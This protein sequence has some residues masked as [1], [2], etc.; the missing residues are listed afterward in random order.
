MAC[1][2]TMLAE[3]DRDGS[4]PKQTRA[5]KPIK[6]AAN[7]RSLRHHLGSAKNHLLAQN[8]VTASNSVDPVVVATPVALG[9]SMRRS[10]M[11]FV[12]FKQT[13]VVALGQGVTSKD[14]VVPS[15]LTQLTNLYNT[16]TV[17]LVNTFQLIGYPTH[18][19]VLN[20]VADVVLCVDIYL[21]FHLSHVVEA[22]EIVDTVQC[23][24]RYLRSTF[25][26]DVLCA[27][28]F[29]V[30]SPSHHALFRFCRLLRCVY[31]QANLTEVE[32]FVPI[33]S[34]KRI[35]L[36][37]IG[38]FVCYHFAGCMVHSLTFAMGF[39]SN[40]HGWLPPKSLQLDNVFSETTGAL[41]GY[42]YMDGSVFVPVDDA[43][44]TK[45]L[46][47][48]YVR[49][50]HN[51][52]VCLTSLS[53]TLEPDVLP[54]YVLAVVLMLSGMLVISLVIDE[55]QKRVTASDM[56]Q[57]EFLSLRS[58]VMHFLHIQKAP[59]EIHRRVSSSM[60]F[61][62]SIHRGANINEMLREVPNSIRRDIYS[63]I[64]APVL[65]LMEQMDGIKPHLEQLT[66]LFL[67]NVVIHLYGQGEI[68]YRRGDYADALYVL[69]VGDIVLVAN[70]RSSKAMP[71]R[72][73]KP[74][75]AVLTSQKNNGMIDPDSNVSVAWETIL[76][77]GAVF[78]LIRVPY[79][80][81]FG[82][83]PTINGRDMVAIVVEVLFAV[84]IVL[85]T[86]TGYYSFGNKVTDKV[87]IRQRY[88]LSMTFV[89]DVVAVLPVDLVNVV[90][91][92]R[93]E[94]LNA[95][96]LVR[97][98]KLSSRIENLERHYYNVSIPI[99]VFKL[100]FYTFLLAHF[101]G[102]TW[103][104]FASDA[105]DVMDYNG[106]NQFGRYPWLP[107]KNMDVA[108]ANTSEMHKYLRVL[109]W[110]LG[111]SLGFYKGEH[112]E[113]IPEYIFTC[114]VQI[115]V[116]TVGVFL[117][118]YLIGNL[119]D[120]VG[121]T[122][123]NNRV[124]YSNLNFV[125]KLTEYFEFSDDVKAKIQHYYFYRLFHTIH[126]EHVLTQCLPQSLVADIR[127]FLLTPM[128]K[129]VPFFQ[130]ET[131]TS[132]ITRSL[133]RQLTQ[134]LVT[135]HEIVCR[136][137]E[138]GVDMYFVFT[139]CLEVYVASSQV[140]GNHGIEFV[141][142]RGTKVN[143]IVAG[144]FF[145]EKSLFSDQPRN[146]SI[147]AKTFCTLY[148]LSRNH[149]ESVFAQ[150]PEWKVKVMQIVTKIYEVQAK[151][152]RE[153]LASEAVGHKTEGIRQNGS[154]KGPVESA[155]SIHNLSSGFEDN[156]VVVTAPWRHTW[157]R[158]L[159]SI[160]IQSRWYRVFLV[161]LCAALLYIAL[162]VPYFVTFGQSADTSSISIAIVVICGVV[163]NFFRSLHTFLT[164]R[165]TSCRT[166]CL[167]F[168]EHSYHYEGTSI[169]LDILAIVPIDYAVSPVAGNAYIWR[170]NR[171]M[172]LRQLAHV[173][174]ELQRFSM[175][176][177][178]HRLQTMA[179]YYS[180]LCYWTACAFFGLT[181][182]VGFST[183]WNS[184]LPH[185]YFQSS[186]NRSD[187]LF[188]LHQFA[189]CCY[190][191][192]NFFTGSG[193]VYEPTV[194][195][196]FVFHC[197][198]A[199]FGVF[200][201]GYIIGEGST[202]CIYLIQ[203]EVDY[204]INQMNVMDFLTR[205]RVDVHLHSRIQKFMTFWWAF[206]NGVPYQM[207]LEQLPS[208]IRAQANIDVA[209][210]SLSRF[211]VR[212]IRPLVHHTPMGIDPVIHS[213]A[214][215][216]VYE[217]YPTGESVIVQGN[218]GHTM[219]FVSTGALVS[220]STSHNFVSVRYDE[221]Q[222]FG[223]DGLFDH[224]ARHYSVVTLRAC[225]LL[226]LTA[227]ALMAALHEHP[228]LSE[229]CKVA[230]DIAA[231][232]SKDL[233]GRQVGAMNIGRMVCDELVRNI[234][235][236]KYL[237][238]MDFEPANVMFG[239]FIHLFVLS[240]PVGVVDADNTTIDVCQHC[241]DRSADQYCK[242]CHQV[243][244]PQ[245]ACDIHD[246]SYFAFHTKTMTKLDKPMSRPLLSLT[247]G[248]AA[249]HQVLTQVRAGPH[250]P[251]ASLYDRM[252]GIVQQIHL[253]YMSFK[254]VSSTTIKGSGRSSG[255]VAPTMLGDTNSMNSISN[256]R[257]TDLTWEIAYK[258]TRT[259]D[260][261]STK[262]Q[263]W[264]TF[265]LV[266][267]LYDAW[268]V[269][270]LTCF[271]QLNPAICHASWLQVGVTAGEFFFLLD[272]YVQMHSRVYLFG[273][274]IRDIKVIRRLYVASWGFPLD[275]VA[276][277]PLAAFLPAS[278]DLCGLD[279][280]NKLLRL[281]KVHAYTLKVD[282]VFARY[283]K[284]C[285]VV[286]AVVVVYFSCHVMAC[287]YASFGKKGDPSTVDDAWKLYDSS[288][289]AHHRR[290]LT[291]SIQ[292]GET[293]QLLTEY[294]ASLFCTL[295]MISKCDANSTEVFDA[296][297]NQLKYIMSFHQVP[298]D[299]QDRAIEYLKDIK[300]ATLQ[301]MVTSVPFFKYCRATFVRALIDLMETQSVP[302]NYILCR[303]GE[304][305]QDMYFV[306]SGVMVVIV[307]NVKV[308]E[309][310]SGHYF[311]EQAIF[312]NQIRSATVVASTFCMLQKLS[313]AH[314][315][316]V[317]QGYPE[318]EGQI[319]ACVST[320]AEEQ[321]KVSMLIQQRSLSKSIGV[322]AVRADDSSASKVPTTKQDVV[323]RRMSKRFVGPI[324]D[325][326][327]FQ[328]D[329]LSTRTHSGLYRL[330]LK[331]PIPRKS[332]VRLVWL[333]TTV[334]NIVV[335]PFIN[336]FDLVGYPVS[337]FILNTLTDVVLW[338]DI[339]G[340]FNLTFVHEAEHVADTIKCANHYYES[341]FVVDLVS[342]FP[343]W[344]VC[345][346]LHIPLRG[347]LHLHAELEEMGL[348]VRIDSRKRIVLLGLGLVLC[349]HIAGCMAHSLTF[350]L[351]Y[352]DSNDGW[353]PPKTIRL[354]KIVDN[355]TGN[356]VG[357]DY[358]DGARFVSLSDP[359]V[360]ECIL[361]QYTRA[362]QYG[363]VCLT[364]LGH[365]LEPEALEEFVLAL[366]LMLSGMLLISML[367]DDVQ[368]CVTASAVEQLQ[369][370]TLRSR[371]MQFFNKEKIPHKIRRRVSEYMD[372]RWSAHR[373]ANMNTLLGELPT[374]IR[375]DI[376]GLICAP[377]L[378]V[379]ELFDNIAPHFDRICE[380]I[381]DNLAVN[382]Y[383]QGELVYNKGEYADALYV[384]VAGDVMVVSNTAAQT[385]LPLRYVKIAACVVAL[386]SRDTLKAAAAEYSNFCQGLLKREQ[387]LLAEHRAMTRLLDQA[388]LA[389]MSQRKPRGILD[390]DSLF[391]IAWDTLLFFVL[392]TQ[393]VAIPFF[394]AF[395]YATVGATS[396][397]MYSVIVE[398][399]FALDMVLKTRTGYYSFGNKVS[400]A[401]KIRYNYFHSAEF[402]WNVVAILPVD[403]VAPGFETHHSEVWRLHKLVRLFTLPGQIEK[404][405]HYFFTHSI[406]IRVLKVV[407]FV[408]LLAHYVGCAWYG[409]ASFG[410]TIWGDDDCPFGKD[411]WLPSQDIALNHPGV[412]TTV[413][414]TRAF[415]WGLGL[416]LGFNK[417]DVPATPWEAV[418]TIVV[419]TV[420]VFLLAYVV[421]N[422]LDVAQIM[423]GNNQ[424]FYSNLTYV[425]KL[426]RYF[427]FT[428]DVR[429]KIQ[430]FYFYRLAHNIHEEHVLTS[431]LPPNLVGDIRLFLLTPMLRK[432]PFFHDEIDSD[433]HVARLLVRH[434]AQ[435]LV[436]R[437]E[438]VCRQH[439]VG[440][441]MYFVF[442]G[443]L[444]VLV[445]Q[446]DKDMSAVR[447]S[448]I[449][450]ETSQFGT[451]V[452][453]LH[454]GSFFGERALFSDQPRTATIQAKTFCTLYKLSRTHLESVFV[455]YPAW[456]AKVIQVVQEYYRIRQI[457][458]ESVEPKSPSAQP[459][460]DVD[461][462]LYRPIPVE[463]TCLRH[464]TQ[465][466]ASSWTCRFVS[467]NQVLEKVVKAVTQIEVQS[468][469]YRGFLNLVRCTLLYVAVREPYMVAF[470]A[471]ITPTVATAA[472]SVRPVLLAQNTSEA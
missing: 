272:V 78:Q 99:R 297:L 381:L 415:Y 30:M 382:L 241:E 315:R 460:G 72:Y 71:Q 191:G 338:L 442:V 360:G 408:Y 116:Q 445:A 50:L 428:D 314:V 105:A 13:S 238:L 154:T 143:E 94:W 344:I 440:I 301:S 155:C 243:L 43:L 80:L 129:K 144:S 147:E 200:V 323:Q 199:V 307:D 107:D 167:P 300:Y 254:V 373:G 378:D 251:P 197:I 401:A 124:F 108:N 32:E 414:Y 183:Q 31:L 365:I 426:T 218:I 379:I 250:P 170:L 60:D 361:R 173:I 61:W 253:P 389:A 98:L 290:R 192:V 40:S 136:Q 237:N 10:S 388:E 413:K 260:P 461:A 387:K 92:K 18:V 462:A 453:E 187:V 176:Y 38:L 342:T 16:I 151:A 404:L 46:V 24:Q 296:K 249:P 281:R 439:D 202:L 435:L 102:C 264:H 399:V 406:P 455:H 368:K 58:R 82:V 451:K 8:L 184:S 386:I 9:G 465:I 351:G 7:W 452:N 201:M 427:D 47:K 48:Q 222:F 169:A 44:V 168:Y 14:K 153:R 446:V 277:L 318:C 320:I 232:L 284:L 248:N 259:F 310:R 5:K 65:D 336:V 100:V 239:N 327:D 207:I 449:T 372:F 334:Y 326:S 447:H 359:L 230:T 174:G 263:L 437:H 141:N 188:S 398:V 75:L 186:T 2:K 409:F 193:R 51:G 23:A 255:R 266:V 88:L 39:T 223:D 354:V 385:A 198:V 41:I 454:A 309:L 109:F 349:Y 469:F 350:A 325:I 36:L 403:I 366:G 57:M 77:F 431:S 303:K 396:R 15:A 21:N 317:M 288:T 374:T 441:D 69:L 424:L 311:G 313:R 84:D 177:E 434:L 126:E 450:F 394:L 178:L 302:T 54:E 96:K 376:Y 55:V 242:L 257:R 438:I 268:I 380:L 275:I 377:F 358:M 89:M 42:H 131:A 236:L 213:I 59:L 337:V 265:L 159:M 87:K 245:C 175:S 456:K 195:L 466:I 298:M 224:A 443:C 139:G 196:H 289:S 163:A 261:D 273:N 430:H 364:D 28:P 90:T 312:I 49:S 432:V 356:L 217:G 52:A 347:L 150:H 113:T 234:C 160:E 463:G 420:G 339:Y 384:L 179:L 128:L 208:R 267:V 119:L 64:C 468:P 122:E 407:F 393:V 114:V 211:A 329:Q 271:G 280:V 246:N 56:D 133:V 127:L 436:T 352:G 324:G 348:F 367:I 134:V 157:K 472:V 12:E 112:P 138:I 278:L 53:L 308:R 457:H 343:L 215:R 316:M 45:V 37:G 209:R 20:T 76:F 146:A 164:R 425:R 86:R 142:H 331:T 104:N 285:K 345:P 210:R 328:H 282:K 194:S 74:E 274:L 162:S 27:F 135:R 400:D 471:A 269:P 171:F 181:F 470:G 165:S 444:N 319:L 299:I 91:S 17:P 286:K 330:L 340:K 322:G 3:R 321:R 244:C 283:Y 369:F 410:C 125:R 448:S 294:F 383:T 333:A 262:M 391:V 117:L 4:D 118:A 6:A 422:L 22:E 111:L 467:P 120:I 252:F 137:N 346:S 411:A 93:M 67:D 68:M 279:L 226:A 95:N 97:L 25:F 375:R 412:S 1:V 190:Y 26:F 417:G 121:V 110:G 459:R 429:T 182:V 270:L 180:V 229:C 235:Q 132:N 204:K 341:G 423:D 227:S 216:L 402:V 291:A 156:D 166:L 416:L 34:R 421:G 206:Q 145:G 464:I 258:S 231:R 335:V 233:N 103:Y 240:R 101:I 123:G 370:M 395:G 185:E 130:N 363:T 276:L 63:S 152:Y 225:D 66:G 148:R 73:V 161:M 419:Q 390:P 293:K 205:K 247:Q 85:K 295:F 158:N 203:N 433:S 81:A 11:H 371:M 212:Y 35:V 189:R 214:H 304:V 221:N 392:A 79:L 362:L 287:I 357:Y 62:W 19:L 306:Q 458:V 106:E 228:R 355:S 172:K 29:W 220:V 397:I 70:T 140:H 83:A 115:V 332:T 292:D 418:F 305:G 353:L 149:L 33:G 256:I 219:Y 405:E